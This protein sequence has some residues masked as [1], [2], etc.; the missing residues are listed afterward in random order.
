MVNYRC[1]TKTDSTKRELEAHGSIL[2]PIAC[3]D[4]DLSIEMVGVHWHEEIEFIIVTE[5]VLTLHIDTEEVKLNI[6]EAIFINSGHLHSASGNGKLNSLV[7]NYTLIGDENTIFFHEIVAPLLENDKLSYLILNSKANWQNVV[8]ENMMSAYTLIRDEGYD[9]ENEARYHIT[10]ALRIIAV[11]TKD[12]QKINKHDEVTYKRIK[13]VLRFIDDSLSDELNNEQLSKLINVSESI[14]LK[15][16]KKTVGASPM[17]YVIK[18]RIDRARYL[19]ITTDKKISTIA[20]ECGF[21]DMSYFAK[22]FKRIVGISPKE[23][24]KER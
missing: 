21:N 22:Q 6:G 12:I 8:I 10:K 20:S 15:S 17:Q 13:K 5:G 11:N 19:I 2:F 18:K 7:F 16:F 3:Y 24:K 4:E 9:Y 14:L 23:Y 1:V